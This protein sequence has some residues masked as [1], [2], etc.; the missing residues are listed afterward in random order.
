MSSWVGYDTDGRTDIGWQDTLRLR[1]RMKRLQLARL[2]ERLAP[3]GDCA[4][5]IVARAGAA[6]AAVAGQIEAAPAK[7]TAEAVQAFAQAMV[8]GQEAALTTPAPL[9]DLFPAAIAAAAD[10]A[11][12]Q[13]LAVQRAGLAAHG[14]ALAHTHVRLN[15][16]QLHNALR[17]RLGL[18]AA[19]M[20]RP[21]GA[22]CSPR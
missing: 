19:P 16:T 15:A 8:G 22:G 1:L 13:A 10:A 21:G 18:A 7:T 17:Q 20:T 11:A 4:A 12:R 9:L 5:P 3:L 6:E 2:I 14:L